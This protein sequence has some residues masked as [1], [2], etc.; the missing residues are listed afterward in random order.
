[1][2]LS[3][4]FL[5]WW[6]LQCHCGQVIKIQALDGPPA[7][8]TAACGLSSCHLPV[9]PHLC[10]FGMSCDLPLLNPSLSPP[11]DLHCF[12]PPLLR[13]Y[14]CLL[15]AVTG[16]LCVH[17]SQQDRDGGREIGRWW[18]SDILPEFRSQM[19]DNLVIRTVWIAAEKEHSSVVKQI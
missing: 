1:M 15:R 8:P 13:K 11:A 16:P 14:A 5:E 3:E 9:S 10:P 2:A 12:L 6:W 19:E 7:F 17:S 18:E 4:R